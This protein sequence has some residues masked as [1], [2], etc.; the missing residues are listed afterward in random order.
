MRIL[1]ALPVILPVLGA[2]L[3]LGA[4]RFAS[5]QRL[6]AL[7]TLAGSFAAGVALL[8]ATRTDGPVATQ[9]GGWPAPYGITL[10]VDTF[11]ALL[12]VVSTAVQ[13]LVLVFALGQ[14]SATEVRRVFYPVY[15]LLSAG[16]SG[17]FVAGD[18]F[19]L[20][21]AF[22]V[23]LT[24]SY[25]MLVLGA[26]ETQ[27]RAAMTYVVCSLVSSLL[28]LTAVALTYAATGTVNLADLA[29]RLNDVP[30]GLR[31]TL[32]LLLLVAFGIKAAVFPLAFWLPDAYPTAPGPVT[33]VFA[34]LLTKVG[35]YALVRTQTL[36]FPGDGPSTPLL[37]LAGTTIVVGTLGAVAQDDLRRLLSFTI[38]GHIG[39]QLLGLGLFSVAGFAGM[40]FYTVHHIVMQTTLFLVAG[41]IERTAGAGALPR[42]G[43]LLKRSPLLALLFALPAAS[44]A[45]LP[46]LSGFVAKLALIQAG[47][48]QG[49]Y[50]VV[51]AALLG[52][53]LTIFA[54][55][56]VWN[57]AF[58]GAAPSVD[59]DTAPPVDRDT[60][61]RAR[62]PLLMT[63]ATGL[64]VAF[65][66]ALAVGA[67]PLYALSRTAAE[68]LIRPTAYV[69]AVLGR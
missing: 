16:V 62:S 5:A 65:G 47:L 19:N 63:G 15:L 67:G 61:P 49:R 48:A 54:M 52:G 21:V 46:P 11:S 20:F 34:G 27:V 55:A 10:V 36:L 53:V 39:Y 64:L 13:L 37:V 57:G 12:V 25:V 50:V 8:A 35:L 3:T 60:A 28:F 7:L 69:E 66:V 40:V 42:I 29:E 1:L 22:E 31:T 44:L 33:A 17:A 4:S 68:E 58:W 51:A 14:G 38:V 30:P 26:G 59:R 24:A 56:R 9:V 18:L 43:G 23:M 2:A 45:G 41:M 6:T 32:G